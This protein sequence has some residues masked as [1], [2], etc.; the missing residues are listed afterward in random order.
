MQSWE[1]TQKL[2]AF[3]PT[4]EISVPGNPAVLMTVKGKLATATPKLSLTQGGPDGPEVGRLEG[5][6]WKT[7]FRI[8]LPDGAQVGQLTFPFFMF[9]KSFTLTFGG[10]SWSAEGGYAGWAFR[11]RDAQGQTVFEIA[12]QATL[13]DRFRV[14]VADGVPAEVGCLAAVAVDQ[15]LFQ[16]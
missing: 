6:F 12:R 8:L 11:C 10:N 15:R 13:R 9:K 7:Q 14:D 5:N 16:Q 4:Y 3:A 2:L 1:V